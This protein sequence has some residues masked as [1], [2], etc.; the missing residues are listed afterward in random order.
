MTDLQ[1]N[2]LAK[3]PPLVLQLKGSQ[4]TM[5]QQLGELL[6]EAG[7]YQDVISYYP[8]MAED[9]LILAAPRKIRN[10]LARSIIRPGL[11]YGLS[12]LNNA[13]IP[14]Y[15]ARTHAAVES[16]DITPATAKSIPIMDLFQN[17][18]GFLSKFKMVELAAPHL[19]PVPAC[20]S[21]VVWDEASQ[22]G[23]ILHARNFDF[24]GVGFWDE[25][26]MI[27]FCTPDKGIP[28]GFIST[29]G[30][31]VPGVSAFNQE[32]INVTFHTRFHR[33]VDF[34]GT[35]VVD[36]GHDIIRRSR[37][38]K[39]AISVVKEHRIASSW[40]ITISSAK[41]KS[42]VL[43]ETTSTGSRVVKPQG[44]NWLVNT[45][46]YFD[47]ELQQGQL[48]TS[49]TFLEHSFNRQKRM[50]Q[51]IQQGI[52]KGGLN[53]ADLESMLGNMTE[54]E[55]LEE[56]RVMGSVLGQYCTV[57]SMVIA[58]SK[59]EVRMS[60]GK[61]PTGWG[62]YITIPMDWSGNVGYSIVDTKGASN[63]SNTVFLTD[64]IKHK[65]YE[66]YR[67]AC[68][69][70]FKGAPLDII[71]SEITSAVA[72]APQ[73]PALN[74]LMG[75]IELEKGNPHKALPFFV[76]GAN[77]EPGVFRK[78]MLHLWAARSAGASGQETLAHEYYRTLLALEH[79]LLSGTQ[80]QAYK[81]YKSGGPSTKT[82]KNIVVSY[83]LIDAHVAA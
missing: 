51:F 39:E 4:L 15:A 13:R 82:L 19:T 75:T 3:Q 77:Q 1:V 55:A 53:S 27:V 20:S 2:R 74:F 7:G 64:S 31:D 68:T 6:H 42:A 54:A 16:T 71:E 72:L 29:R 43:I 40:G 5:G 26:P 58:P 45:N 60:V 61:A 17:S 36:L 50:Q 48:E 66:H 24:P 70:D 80:A 78:G 63:Q 30:A 79:S 32:G 52:V 76:E 11:Q 44:G 12:K 62:P 10:K 34:N 57:S 28:Y 14:E 33:D 18:V 8:R 59:A 47:P 25:S 83:M 35:P 73:D 37:T 65:A 21:A 49:A 81:E 69:H 22:D 9:L 46:H 23:D 38:L 67:A 41:E 56:E